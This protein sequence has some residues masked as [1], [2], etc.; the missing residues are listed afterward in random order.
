MVSL[1]AKKRG[2]VLSTTLRALAPG[3]KTRAFAPGQII[4]SAGDAGDGFYIVV[5]GRVQ[6]SAVVGPKESRVLATIGAGDFFGEMAVVDDAPRSAT[7]TAEVYT[8]ARFVERSKLLTL[9]QRRPGLALSIIREF[10]A[11]AQ[12][13][14]EVCGG[15]RAGGTARSH[16]PVRDDHRA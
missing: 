3:A 16:R 14:P 8:R 10:S 7:A 1:K 6:I 2:E 13:E 12:S 11:H 4:F 9:L 15:N 5:A